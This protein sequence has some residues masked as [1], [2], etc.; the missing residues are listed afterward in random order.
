MSSS[1]SHH[2]S[3]TCLTLGKRAVMNE[4]NDKDMCKHSIKVSKKS[5]RGECVEGGAK[6]GMPVVVISWLVDHLLFS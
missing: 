1:T 6:E 5:V 4:D 3:V 2:F